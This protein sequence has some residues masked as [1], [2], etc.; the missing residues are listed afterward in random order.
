MT[1]LEAEARA[2]LAEEDAHRLAR[3]KEQV[4]QRRER[5]RQEQAHQET[6]AA[7]AARLKALDPRPIETARQQLAAALNALA[8]AVGHWN[9]ELAAVRDDVEAAGLQAHPSVDLY[10]ADAFPG[11]TIGK[12]A[13]RPQPLQ[14]TISELSREVIRRH[15]PRYSVSLDS[16]QD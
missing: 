1:T 4:Q 5:E 3:A 11:I 6:L 15:Y 2:L 10:R 16:P 12:V 9:S 14:R 13:A 8:V 7:A